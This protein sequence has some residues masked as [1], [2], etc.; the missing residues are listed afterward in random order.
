MFLARMSLLFLRSLK[1]IEKGD[2]F[3]GLAIILCCTGN[4][5]DWIRFFFSHKKCTFTFLFRD[6]YSKSVFEFKILRSTFEQ[7]E[8]Y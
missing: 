8:E 4:L 1:W 6:N 7:L 2:L 5:G 3:K